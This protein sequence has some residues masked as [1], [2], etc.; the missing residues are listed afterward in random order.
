MKRSS[1]D[2]RRLVL[3]LHGEAEVKR[4]CTTTCSTSE[5]RTFACASAREM[6]R[7]MPARRAR[8]KV[9]INSP[10]ALP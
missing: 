6:P 1:F 3:R 5:S 2:Q 10:T 8:L 9:K 4:S 7:L